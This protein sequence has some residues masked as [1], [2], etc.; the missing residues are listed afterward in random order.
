MIDL[1]MRICDFVSCK[2]INFLGGADIMKQGL[3]EAVLAQ[4]PP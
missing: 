1:I 4:Q 3:V 2:E